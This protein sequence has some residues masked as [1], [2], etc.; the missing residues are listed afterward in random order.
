MPILRGVLGQLRGFVR[1]VRLGAR[2]PPSV[3]EQVV[4]EHEDVVDALERRDV[5]RALTAL[6][7][8]LYTSD[9]AISDVA[10][11]GREET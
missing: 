2:R 9:Y 8:H 3:L 11:D 5:P 1:V 4:R 7:D 10:P 6:R